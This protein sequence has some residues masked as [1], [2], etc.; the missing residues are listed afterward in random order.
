MSLQY[1]KKQV[2]EEVDF[3]YADKHQ[4]FL[5]VDY[6]NLGIKV[7]YK[8]ILFDMI[9]IDGHDQAFS[10]YSKQQVCNIFTISQKRSYGWSSFL[11]CR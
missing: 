10:K 1:L 6:N 8:V 3:L 7:L 5:Q 2:R 4:S 11:K 9:I